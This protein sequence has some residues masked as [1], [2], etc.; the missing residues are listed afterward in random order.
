VFDQ[1]H[2]RP[3]DTVAFYV[4]FNRYTI[5][6]RQECIYQKRGTRS[7]PA[8]VCTLCHVDNV[9][10]NVAH[11]TSAPVS[12]FTVTFVQIISPFDGDNPG[13]SY[14]PSVWPVQLFCREF[15]KKLIRQIYRTFNT[16]QRSHYWAAAIVKY[17]GGRVTENENKW[18]A[19]P[20]LFLVSLTNFLRF[21]FTPREKPPCFH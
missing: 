9:R 7:R 4:T 12:Y 1:K 13:V 10:Y 19:S 11:S 5:P 14:P 16:R 20:S 6:P 18:S 15:T 2:V 8:C 21:S 3:L 17:S